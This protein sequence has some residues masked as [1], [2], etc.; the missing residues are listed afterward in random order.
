[1]QDKMKFMLIGL[2][3]A[4]ILMLFFLLQSIQS[5]SR[6]KSERDVLKETNNSLNVQLASLSKENKQIK[7]DFNSAK[8]ELDG[9]QAEKAEAENAFRSLS[10]ERTK[11]QAQLQQL[12]AKMS[13]M[14]QPPAPESGEPRK[15]VEEPPASP[16]A[17]AYW[18]GVL[19]KKAELELK[20]ENVRAELKT[21]KL[22][23]EQIRREKD[24]LELDMQSYETDQKDAKREFEYN[25]KLADNLTTE[26]TREKTDKF[27]LSDTLK[28][29]K[30][31]NKYLKQQLKVLYD[32][33]T[34]LEEKFSDLQDKNA[35][36]ESNMAKMESFVREKILQVDSLKSDLG[37]MSPQARSVSEPS[38]GLSPRK[39]GAI[40]L[41]PIVVRQQE[42]VPS[43]PENP[44]A[45]IVSVIAINKDNNFAILNTGSSSGVKVGD[46]FQIFRQDEPVAVVEVIQ[47]RENIS[48]CDIKS[49]NTPIAV[50]DTAK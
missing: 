6:L 23:N 30:N 42:A 5:S 39:K 2:A 43:R 29:L 38:E 44:A 34:K 48:A 50:G 35:V 40:E 25:K 4:I 31:E 41:Q 45:K 18:A 3:A 13:T 21:A 8:K 27:Q 17:D 36:L 24:K 47:A 11:L 33:K 7:E 9:F 32:H 19:K 49:E 14:Q 12:T 28:S 10:E 15:T 26:L 46:T 37:V 1:M 20:L 16:T 22:D